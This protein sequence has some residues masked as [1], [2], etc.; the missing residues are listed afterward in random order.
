MPNCP[1]C[2]CVVSYDSQFCPECGVNIVSTSTNQTPVPIIEKF[3]HCRNCGKSLNANAFACTGCGVPPA[4]GNLFCN[5]CGAPSHP[6]AVVCIKCGV[7]FITIQNKPSDSIA[8]TIQNIGANL[9]GF[10]SGNAIK[11][12]GFWAA[13]V[14]F[15]GF[16]LP[17]VDIYIFSG[18]GFTLATKMLSD[19]APIRILLLAIPIVSGLIIFNLLSGNISN[20]LAFLK[21]IPLAALIISIL[22]V[23]STLDEGGGR[24]FSD[25]ESSNTDEILKVLGIGVWMTLIGCILL[26]FT[27][28]SKK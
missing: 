24:H 12:I 15:L 7:S 17:W 13:V 22:G 21:F 26:C 18:N 11:Q 19:F 9:S 14:C 2:N 27:K 10:Q 5:T 1:K 6:E 25:F 3:I 4:K 16:F 20:S 23:I 8:N 28:T